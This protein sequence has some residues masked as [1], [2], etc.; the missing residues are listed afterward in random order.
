MSGHQYLEV[1]Q[2]TICHKSN[3]PVTAGLIGGQAWSSYTGFLI[4]FYWFLYTGTPEHQ[5]SGKHK[6]PP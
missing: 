1:F 3:D 5:M 2:F 6:T 4:R